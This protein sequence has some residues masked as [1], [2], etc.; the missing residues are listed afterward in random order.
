MA[1]NMTAQSIAVGDNWTK[2]GNDYIGDAPNGG[3]TPLLTEDFAGGAVS[4][5][6]SSWTRS[7]YDDTR[8]AS[9]TKSLKISSNAGEPPATCGGGHFFAGRSALPASI[10]EGK[11]LWV[12]Y[13]VFHPST[14]SWGY[15]FSTGDG[16]DATT[17]SKN[18]DGSGGLKYM[19]VAPDTGTARI[20]Y[21][22]RVGRRST[23]YV[24]T[25]RLVSEVGANL[26]PVVTWGLTQDAWNTI[27]MEIYVHSGAEGYVRYWINDTF[28]GQLDGATISNSG[29][30]ISE[31]GM[32]DYWNGV[33]YTDSAGDST[34]EDFWLDEVIIATDLDGYGAP[35]TTDSGG[36]A[37]I[38]PATT[39]GDFA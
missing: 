7:V 10:P 34:R 9:G 30:S 24:G 13:K 5:A 29:Y 6:Y 3:Y 39:V 17:C 33:P 36:R 31:W 35:T 22:P 15:C 37:Y 19:V 26:S 21:S 38:A 1:V 20:Y 8:A 25:V 16:A 28:L 23:S 11:K 12:S 27:Q 4:A 14:F 18:A 32:G 2:I